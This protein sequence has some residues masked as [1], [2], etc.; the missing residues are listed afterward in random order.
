[1]VRAL[2][3]EQGALVLSLRVI[4]VET[5]AM[6]G[7]PENQAQEEVAAQ[8]RLWPSITSLLRLLQ[9]MEVVVVVDNVWMADQQYLPCP[10]L[11]TYCWILSMG[12]C[13]LVMGEAAEAAEVDPP[14]ESME[15]FCQAALN[16]LEPEDIADRRWF[17]L[18]LPCLE[19]RLLLPIAARFL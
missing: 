6:Q 16:S 10:Y 7:T 19:P 8:H 12:Q 18:K 15:G 1:M 17:L 14:A 4:R 2:E 11:R 13:H 9:G 3:V 5:V